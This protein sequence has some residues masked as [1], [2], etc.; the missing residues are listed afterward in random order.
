M[1]V[2][3][4]FRTLASIPSPTLKE[5]KVAKKI[6]EL[7]SLK[8][9]T[10]Q[11]DAYGNVYGKVK[12]TD[13]TKPPLM[14]SAHMDV[15][16]DNSPV[17]IKT[18]ADGKFYETDKTRT[19]GADDK[20]GIAV[21]IELIQ[22]LNDNV[23]LLHGGL[24]F[25]FTRDEEQNLTGVRNA[26][27][28]KFLSQYILVLDADCLGDFL[29]AGAGYTKMILEVTAPKG[30]HSGIDIAD[31]SRVNAVKLLAQAVS[32]IPQGVYKQDETGVVAS[33]NIGAIA[34]GG[35]Q[36]QPTEKTGAEFNAF[37]AQNAVTNVINTNAYASYSI[38]SSQ[39]SVEE[40]LKADILN[41]IDDLN[42]KYAEKAR[43]EVTFQEHMKPFEAARETYLPD[44]FKQVAKEHQVTPRIASFHAGAET[45]VFTYEKNAK[46]ETFKPYL[47]GAANIYDMHSANERVEISSLEKGFELIKALFLKFNA[48]D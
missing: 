6:I 46:E 4:T 30:G 35:L 22:Y 25:L 28:S 45:H 40:D 18:S 10:V 34:G 9:V 12:A 38:R 43:F 44:L 13:D 32:L 26:D 2:T 31:T 14:V 37:L 5:E 19:L 11:L 29:I 8:N 48:I 27:C 1:S 17:I 47:V 23:T 3:Q 20:A 16:G 24:E 15:V 39:K 21:A 36:N 42:R 7:L 41:I 33:I